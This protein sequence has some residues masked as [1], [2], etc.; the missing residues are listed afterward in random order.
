[1]P[2]MGG[3]LGELNMHHL[4]NFPL[5]TFPWSDARTNRFHSILGGVFKDRKERKLEAGPAF[6]SSGNVNAWSH[7]ISFCTL[8]NNK[9]RRDALPDMCYGFNK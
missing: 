9:T 3:K 7:S 4:Q 1:M 5:K 2:L 6:V 8:R